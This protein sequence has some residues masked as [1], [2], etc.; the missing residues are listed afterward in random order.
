MRYSQV[1]K[2]QNK[3]FY[4]SFT[5]IA[6]L[7]VFFSW[8]FLLLLKS[9][10]ITLTSEIL[11]ASTSQNPINNFQLAPYPILDQTNTKPNSARYWAIFDADSQKII[12]ENQGAKVVPIASTTKIMTAALVLENVSDLNE[13]VEI[14]KDILSIYQSQPHLLW[15]E[16]Y[17]VRD[18]LYLLMLVSDNQAANTL[19][20]YVGGRKLSMSANWDQKRSEFIKMMNNKAMD[21]HLKNTKFSDPAGLELSSKST[22]KDLAKLTTY[23]LKN[24]QFKK[25][26]GTATKTISNT[27]QSRFLELKNTNRLVSEWFYPG[28]IGV[29]TGFLPNEPNNLSA[30]HCL[31]AAAKQNNHTLITVVLN[32]YS[33]HNE[34]SASAARDLLNF[35]F[36][37]TNWY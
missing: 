8:Y 33:E 26:V 31:V 15:G 3:Y 22:A 5:V 28:I 32:T 30:G 34:A 25:I 24:N 27:R 12:S 2:L 1:V 14:E 7:M 9:R 36:K 18:L 19:A 6:L 21:L 23:A 37:N 17:T 35:G 13:P 29:K 16:N 4:Y 10:P 11:G 20:V